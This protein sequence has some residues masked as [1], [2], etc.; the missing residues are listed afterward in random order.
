MVWLD[1]EDNP[2]TG[3]SWDDW[4]PSSNCDYINELIDATLAH[5]VQVGVYTS[6]YEW[7]SVLGSVSA[8]TNAARSGSIPLW[9]AHFD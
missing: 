9:Y 3:C 7:N 1:I 5:G 8:C 4:T 2:S 6:E